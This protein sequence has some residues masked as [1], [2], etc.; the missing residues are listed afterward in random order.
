MEESITN[1]TRPQLKAQPIKPQNLQKRSD[2]KY[3]LPSFRVQEIKK[4]GLKEESPHIHLSPSLKRTNEG[5]F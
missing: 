4:N 3:H 1:T 2:E 5:V